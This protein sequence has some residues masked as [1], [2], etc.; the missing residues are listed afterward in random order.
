MYLF[1]W[2]L[3]SVRSDHVTTKIL[4]QYENNTSTVSSHINLL[5]PWSDVHILASAI[6]YILYIFR[7]TDYI[8]LRFI[9]FN[10]QDVFV[11][12]VHIQSGIVNM[13]CPNMCVY[14][15]WTISEYRTFPYLA[16]C[17]IPNKIFKYR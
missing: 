17:Q 15:M 4:I 13:I 6:L 1:L 3:G 9:L 11:R 7:P 10:L 8:I 14:F 12:N 5:T 16:L 2:V